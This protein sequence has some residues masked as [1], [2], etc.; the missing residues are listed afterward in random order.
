M[1]KLICLSLLACL[2]APPALAEDGQAGLDWQP[3]PPRLVYRQ[4]DFEMKTTARIQAD[5]VQI[6]DD[7]A[8]H[9][10]GLEI[11]RLRLGISAALSPQFSFV[12]TSDFQDDQ[13]VLKDLFLVYQPENADWRMTAGHFKEPFGME[14]LESSGTVLFMER[15]ALGGLNPKRNSG[16]MLARFA[17]QWSISGGAF[18]KSPERDSTRPDAAVTARATYAPRLQADNRV[19]L[20][21]AGSFR[22]MEQVRFRAR[23]ETAITHLSTVDTGTFRNSDRMTLLGL[24]AAYGWRSLLVQSEYTRADVRLPGAD[25]TASGWYVQGGWILTGEQ[26]PYSPAKG[27]V[28]GRVVPDCPLSPS[29][30]CWGAL[31]LAA[32]I[33]ALDLT[34]RTFSGG[35][36]RALTA[37]VNW[38]PARNVRLTGNISKVTTDSSA[39]RPD[40]DPL[41]MGL[42]LQLEF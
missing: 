39:P 42:R 19:H 1:R 7:V 32:R 4:Q 26:R 18:T 11:R 14:E 9:S 36:Q 34:D 37:G 13:H 5:A 40:D 21:V 10:D 41:V 12:W 23:P 25:A 3:L 27:A 28:F 22:E 24:E 6:D 8:D 29:A 30:G 2:V 35:R 20:G 17:E 31:E 15:S 38:Y 16:V 33:S